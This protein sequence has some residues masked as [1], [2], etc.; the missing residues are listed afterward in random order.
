MIAVAATLA[1]SAAAALAIGTIAASV[2]P[3]RW[4]IVRL[5]AGEIDPPNH[6]RPR[7]APANMRTADHG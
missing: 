2:A 6:H 7:S 1:F 3:Q 5:A 4:R